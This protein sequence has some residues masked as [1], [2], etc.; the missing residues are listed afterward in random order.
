[1]VI[2]SF[3]TTLK[4]SSCDFRITD[5]LKADV[6]VTA[7]S[8]FFSSLFSYQLPMNNFKTSSIWSVETTQ[9]SFLFPCNSFMLIL[10][11][12]LYYYK[13]T[14]FSVERHDGNH[15]DWWWWHEQNEVSRTPHRLVSLKSFIKAFELMRKRNDLLFLTTTCIS[16]KL[17]RLPCQMRFALNMISTPR[18][19]D[20]WIV[21]RSVCMIE[22]DDNVAHLWEIKSFSDAICYQMRNSSSPC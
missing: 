1:M 7:A 10:S 13:F 17:R 12:L 22:I 20:T 5:D 9:S 11:H 18:P 14:S 15:R 4:Y 19:T 3:F 8:I 2:S 16:I 6:S 21:F